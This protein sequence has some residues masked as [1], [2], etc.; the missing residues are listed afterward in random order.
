M[1]VSL[2]Q[3]SGSLDANAGSV[4][5]SSG[6]SMTIQLTSDESISGERTRA[7][8]CGKRGIV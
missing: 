4:Y 2:A 8:T 5:D 3:L 7:G 1:G 6:N